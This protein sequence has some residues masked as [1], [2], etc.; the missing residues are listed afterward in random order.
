MSRSCFSFAAT[1]VRS[2]VIQLGVGE[3]GA[4]RV[5]TVF[6]GNGKTLRTER[7]QAV[8]PP[9]WITMGGPASAKAGQNGELCHGPCR[10][11][12]ADTLVFQPVHHLQVRVTPPMARMSCT[13]RCS[14]SSAI[15]MA[16]TD[17]VSFTLLCVHQ[18]ISYESCASRLVFT[19]YWKQIVLVSARYISPQHAHTIHHTL[20]LMKTWLRQ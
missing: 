2:T 1:R 18:P 5:L 16:P 4:N 17:S 20:T 13:M 6:A 3:H 12:V 8:F 14:K 11:I 7:A 9:N 19:E 10:R 15:P